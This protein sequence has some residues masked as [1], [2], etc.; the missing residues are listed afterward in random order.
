VKEEVIL[1]NES[2]EVVGVAEK[3]ATHACAALHRAFSIFVFSSAGELLL[4]KRTTTKYHS[5][6]L[7]SN[8]CCGHP[9]PGESTEAASQRRLYEEMGFECEVRKVFSFTYYVELEN[10]FFEHE[11]DHVFIG[12]FDGSPKPSP[13]EVEDWKWMDLATLRID[14]QESPEDFT[15]WFKLSF[16]TLCKH[17]WSTDVLGTASIVKEFQNA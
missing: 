6:G 14:M 5:K 1:V 17:V 2:D 9:R 15:Y 8:T 7:W 12:Q 13:D 10:G 4:Q 16:D 11:Y 3:L